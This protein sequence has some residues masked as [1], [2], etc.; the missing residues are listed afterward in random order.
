MNPGK[1]IILS[2]LIIQKIL[3]IKNYF[4]T[5]IRGIFYIR[6]IWRKKNDTKNHHPASKKDLCN[7]VFTGKK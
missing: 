3:K 2:T 4:F 5:K 6:C 7:S 1:I